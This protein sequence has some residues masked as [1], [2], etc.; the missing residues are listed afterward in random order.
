MNLT[1]LKIEI[2]IIYLFKNLTFF[3]MILK[4]GKGG[5]YMESSICLSLCGGFYGRGKGKRVQILEIYLRPM[6][7]LSIFPLK[8][9]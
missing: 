4:I 5:R 9:I 2:I 1:L 3:V 6:G 7:W 8:L